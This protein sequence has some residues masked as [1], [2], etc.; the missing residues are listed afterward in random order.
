MLGTIGFVTAG[1]IIALFAY[2]SNHAYKTIP[3]SIRTP[4]VAA[5]GLLAAAMFVW[6]LVVASNDI[7]TVIPLMLVSDILL[8]LATAA[9]IAILT[10]FARRWWMITLLGAV[11]ALLT[12][13]RAYDYQPEAYVLDGL[14]YFNVSQAFLTILVGTLVATWLPAAAIIATQATAPKVLLPLRKPLVFYFISLV[15]ITAAFLTAHRPEMIVGLFFLVGLF[16]ALATA[17][18]VGIDKV[19]QKEAAHHGK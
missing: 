8:L 3:F 11:I 14:L 4:F 19:L 13:L 10:P 16:F 1:V 2:T 7:D 6:A 17:T 18:N 15:L 12:V 5:Y 9:N